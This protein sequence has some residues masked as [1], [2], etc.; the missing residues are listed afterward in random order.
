MTGRRLRRVR[1]AAR[2]VAPPSQ[3]SGAVL[4]GVA[5][6]HALAVAAMRKTELRIIGLLKK[7]EGNSSRQGQPFSVFP[8][9]R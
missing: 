6:G 4:R 7:R 3:R 5:S 2:A 8:E 1:G 9:I